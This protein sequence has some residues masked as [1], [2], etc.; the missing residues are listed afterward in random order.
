LKFLKLNKQTPL[1]NGEKRKT[2]SIPINVSYKPVSSPN[3]PPPAPRTTEN[4]T[5]N[6]ALLEAIKSAVDAQIIAATDRAYKYADSLAR[7]QLT[8]VT[9]EITELRTRLDAASNPATVI[10]GI[11][12]NDAAYAAITPELTPARTA[13]IADLLRYVAHNVSKKNYMLVGHAGVGKTTLASQLA[14]ARK[15]QYGSVSCCIGMSET[16]ILGRQTPNGYVE[17]S[18]VR[19]YRD[20][21]VF[22]FDEFDA[23]DSN[24]VIVVNSA[25]DNGSFFNPI[26]GETLTRHPDCIILAGCNTFGRGADSTYTARNRLDR[27]TLSRFWPIAMGYDLE[28]ERKLCPDKTLLETLWQARLKLGELSSDEMI[29]TRHIR[30]AYLAQ[31]SGDSLAA[32][33][34]PITLPWTPGLAEQVGLVVKEAVAV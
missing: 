9:S 4:P 19:C 15:L 31:Q 17:S 20:G 32:V 10:A 14:Q 18:F 27:A 6:A 33:Y 16:W 25:L 34:A 23:S 5:E 22:L 12:I 30:D 1:T 26:S 28:L 8:A 13:L 24:T 3:T 2:M 21:G 29:T 11:S 7:A